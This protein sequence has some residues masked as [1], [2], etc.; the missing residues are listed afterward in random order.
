MFVMKTETLLLQFAL[1]VLIKNTE[2]KRG[3]VCQSTVLLNVC[4]FSSGGALLLHEMQHIL[5][6][7]KE[8]H[9]KTNQQQQ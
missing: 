3:R 1:F 5:N 6:Y 9:T 4:Y 8:K 2:S 7:F